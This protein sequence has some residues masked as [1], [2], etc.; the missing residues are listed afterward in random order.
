MGGKRPREDARRP[1]SCLGSGRG[2][3]GLS[4]RRPRSGQSP[5]RG[6]TFAETVH[7]R[8]RAGTLGCRAGRGCEML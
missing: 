3:V 6:K 1:R 8:C 2:V 4:W 7:H 5:G